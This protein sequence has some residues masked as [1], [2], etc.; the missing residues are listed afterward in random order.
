MEE[1]YERMM[2]IFAY[3]ERIREEL[4]RWQDDA[5]KN[6]QPFCRLN[7]LRYDNNT[8][9]PDYRWRE[10]RLLYLLRYTYAYAYIYKQA[11][12]R[13]FREAG[14][15]FFRNGLSVVSL[16]CG[17]MIDNW[18]LW[19]ALMQMCPAG[20]TPPRYTGVDIAG[21][22][23]D[24]RYLRDRLDFQ[25]SDAI[26]WLERQQALDAQ[27][28]IFPMSISEFKLDEAGTPSFDSLCARFADESKPVTHDRFAIILTLRGSS[29]NNQD[30]ERRA[31]RLREAVEKRGFTCRTIDSGQMPHEKKIFELGDADF[32]LPAEEPYKYTLSNIMDG[33]QNQDK[34]I[35]RNCPFSGQEAACPTGEDKAECK[36]QLEWCPMLSADKVAYKV[37]LFDRRGQ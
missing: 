32:V 1:R 14:E 17:T 28:Y 10:V 34:N 25:Q 21:W 19:S 7:K 23:E 12:L 5:A 11:Y 27:V 26:A 13:L 2:T 20:W 9:T 18:S 6:D 37:L 33:F 35:Y 15:G 3:L 22:D 36:K 31:S 24:L 16:G 8:V 4:D 29:S 30:D